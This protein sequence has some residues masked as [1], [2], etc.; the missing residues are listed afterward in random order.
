MKSLSIII[1]SFNEEKNIRS[2]L[3]NVC[4]LESIDNVEIIVSDGN[5]T[6]GTR[7]CIDKS[8]KVLVCEPN[9]SKQMAKAVEA[10]QGE[11]LWFLHADMKLPSNALVQIKNAINKGYD[12][13]GFA[14]NFDK[15]N[16]KIKR[17]GTIMNLRIFDKKEQSDKGVF[18]GDNAIFITKKQLHEIGGIPQQEIM[19]DYELSVRLKQNGAKMFKIKNSPIIVSSRR[20][21]EEGFIR[22]RLRWILIRKLYKWGLDPFLLK[23]L[24]SDER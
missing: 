20:H 6:D 15:Y 14:N 22:T 19:E 23:K 12:G 17:L 8:I 9:R 11:V 3:N 16:D 18:Y 4:S 5:S 7:E 24:Y 21:I 10:A 1:L 13:G 2:I